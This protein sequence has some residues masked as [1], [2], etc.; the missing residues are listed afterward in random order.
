MI[1]DTLGVTV[2][3][4]TEPKNIPPVVIKVI[5]IKTRLLV[6]SGLVFSGAGGMEGELLSV[7][8]KTVTVAVSVTKSVIVIT[9]SKLPICLLLGG[10]A[11]TAIASKIVSHT[12]AFMFEE[13]QMQRK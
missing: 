4:L 12:D 8:W 2:D 13:V 7:C 9:D 1:T 5:G 6:A 3:V 10:A 11:V